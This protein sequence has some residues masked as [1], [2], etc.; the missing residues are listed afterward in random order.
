MSRARNM[1]SLSAPP[2]P[3]THKH[4]EC[5]IAMLTWLAF[6]SPYFFFKVFPYRLDAIRFQCLEKRMKHLPGI[7]RRATY[8]GT[9]LIRN[10]A[11]LEPNSR[12]MPRALKSPRGG[13]CFLRARYLCTPLTS[14]SACRSSERRACIYVPG[15]G[16]RGDDA[17]MATPLEA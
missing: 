11:P 17:E 12:T 2:P 4:V 9:S 1:L 3:F 15:V 10:S 5:V 7:D 8:R 6:K 13:G 16:R 14:E